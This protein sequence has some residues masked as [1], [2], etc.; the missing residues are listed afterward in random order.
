MKTNIKNLLNAVCSLIL[1]ICIGISFIALH[2]PLNIKAHAGAIMEEDSVI[3]KLN[4]SK[5]KNYTFS[6]FSLDKMEKSSYNGVTYKETYGY[7][8]FKE[9][10]ET[11]T[12]YEND[13]QKAQN[14][15]VYDEGEL[16]K[17]IQQNLGARN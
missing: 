17:S 2:I 5:Q 14:T 13:T 12:A 7:E 3:I 10:L 8:S 6:K 16:S 11:L 15:M 4:V 9:Y 1:A